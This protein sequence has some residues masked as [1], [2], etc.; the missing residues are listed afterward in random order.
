MTLRRRYESVFRDLVTALDL[1]PGV[2]PRAFRLALL[3]A[4]NWALT[5]YRP[6]GDPPETVARDLLA[7][8]RAGQP[9]PPTNRIARP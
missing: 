2:K 4:L 5:W 6:G 3:G 8:F 9:A 7:V 1:P